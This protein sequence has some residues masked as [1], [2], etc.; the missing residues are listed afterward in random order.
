MM[1]MFTSF[2]QKLFILTLLCKISL[3]SPNDIGFF[4]T[5]ALF[6]VLQR[7]YQSRHNAF[8][9]SNRPWQVYIKMIL[10]WD[11]WSSLS[12]YDIIIFQPTAY[13]MHCDES[14]ISDVISA[15]ETTDP[16]CRVSGKTS[17]CAFLILQCSFSTSYTSVNRNHGII[18]HRNWEIWEFNLILDVQDILLQ[19]KSLAK[20]SSSRSPPEPWYSCSEAPPI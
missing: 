12:S 8:K 14:V 19:T 20:I 18:A 7:W 1:Q 6:L 4:C 11:N 2:L 17:N 5:I 15:G 10:Q 13:K 16:S 9:L 3:F